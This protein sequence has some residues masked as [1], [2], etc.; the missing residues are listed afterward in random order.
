MR[1]LITGITGFIGGHLTELLLREDCTIWGTVFDPRE[2]PN[3]AKVVR[4]VHLLDCDI[5]DPAAV[6]SVVEQAKPGLVFHLAA[7]MGGRS[8][9]DHRQPAFQVNL[10]ATAHLLE[11]IRTKA[12]SATILIPVSSAVFGIPEDPHEPITEEAPYR[13]VNPYGAS[14]AAQSMLAHQYGRTYKMNVIRVH[15][16]NCIG[17]RQSH[18][19]AMSNFARQIAEIEK[20]L[21]PPII[22][23]GDLDAY[24][25]FTDVRDVVRAYWL[26]AQG[27]RRGEAYNICSGRACRVGDALAELIRL[28]GCS[29]EIRRQSQ[30]GSPA[31]VPYQVGDSTK[32]RKLTGWLPSISVER[33]LMDTL[34]YWRARILK[35]VPPKQS[36]LREV[37]DSPQAPEGTQETSNEWKQTGPPDSLN[38][39]PSRP[40]KELS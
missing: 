6:E 5:R 19:F 8:T 25:D 24:R 15:T 2:L 21:R 32:F 37:S 28:S 1:A 16:F 13:P 11:A 3:V 33:S 40:G 39:Q 31:A 27:G 9:Q 26:A 20:G 38:L 4:H 35:P 10:L 23:V 14:K 17:P 18:G 30:G 34:D 7:Y 29:I 12:P 36:P 22:Q